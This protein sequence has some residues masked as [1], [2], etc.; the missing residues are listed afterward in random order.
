MNKTHLRRKVDK[1]ESNSNSHVDRNDLAEL[2]V[3][4]MLSYDCR[5]V[6]DNVV[7]IPETGEL[8]GCRDLGAMVDV[9]TFFETS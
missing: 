7:R 3:V 5:L 4:E 8:R 2:T 9:Q 1:I 6:D